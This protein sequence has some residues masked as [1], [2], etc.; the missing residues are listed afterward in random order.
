MEE[1]KTLRD[2][3][4]FLREQLFGETPVAADDPYGPV[5]DGL[6]GLDVEAMG[7][8]LAYASGYLAGKCGFETADEAPNE[9]YRAGYRFGCAVRAGMA[10]PYWDRSAAN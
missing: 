3:V 7:Q 8:S 4:S 10:A 6:A 1:V 9:D 2:E 5:L